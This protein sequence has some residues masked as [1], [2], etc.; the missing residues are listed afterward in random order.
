MEAAIGQIHTCMPLRPVTLKGTTSDVQG[1]SLGCGK[2]THTQ[3][4]I[5]VS[6]K[7]P[8]ILGGNLRTEVA[9][10]PR[11][12]VTT[13][14]AFKTLSL[15]RPTDF[16]GFDY[17]GAFLYHPSRIKLCK[18]NRVKTFKGLIFRKRTLRF[19]SC[20][21]V[22]AFWFM[23]FVSCNLVLRFANL[24]IKTCVLLRR[25]SAQ[26]KTSLHFVS[27]VAGLRDRLPMLA[28][29]RYPQWRSRFLR[30]I[31]TRPNG[32]AL[33]KCILNGPYIP[34]T[35][36]S[37]M[38][39]TRL[40]MLAKQLRKYEKLSKGYNKP[41]WSRF[42]T[43]VKQ[44]HK[45]DEVSYHKL[46]DILKQYQKEVNELRAKRL[47][48]NAN[49]LPLVAT[50][51]ANQDPY[52]QT[53]KSHKSYAPS[54]KP[55]IPTRS[56]TTTRYKGK[57]IAKP[58]TPPSESAF[59]EDSDPEQAQRDKDM[60]KNDNQSGQF[61]NQRIL[62][63]AGARENV[64]SLVVQ[65][66]RIQC[67][68]SK[69]FGHF[70][71]ECGKPKRVKDS[72]YHKEKM[73]LCKQAEKG[74]VP[75]AV[76]GTDSEPLEKV[77]ND[78]RYN[79]FA[80]DLQHSEQ[81]GSISN[82]CIV[83]TNDS[84]VIPDSPEMC[85]DDIQNDQNDVESD[86][87]RVALANLIVNFK[88]DVDENK[89]IQKQL[90]KANTTL[91]QE[92]K[93]C[94]TI[95]T[96]IS[97]TLGESN[98]VRDS[99]LITLQN[100][101]IE[102]E[103]YKAFN[104]R[105][106]DYDKLKRKLNE[107]LGQ[108]A[109]KDIEIKEG[110]KLKAYEIS[111]VKE[112]HDELIKQSLLTKSQYEGLVKQKTKV[113][114]DLK[115]KEEH[116]IDKMLSL[117]KQVTFLNEIVYKQN[118]SIQTIHMMVPKVP[119]YNGRPTFANPS[120]LKQDQSE[121]PCLYAFPYDQ[122]THAN[123]LIPDGGSDS[124]SRKREP[125]FR[126][127]QMKDKVVPNNSQVKLKKTQVE[128]HPRIPS[129]SNKNKSVIACN[130][131]LNSRTSNANAVCAT[132]RKCFVDFDHFACVTKMLN[133][134][135]A[136]TKKPHVVPIS[137]RKPKGHANKSIATPHKKKV[138]S[139]STTQKP[140]SY[141]RML[142]GKSSKAWKW[143]IEQQ[144]P[145]GY[146]WV[147]MTKM[148]W[149]PKARNENVQKR[150]V[151]LILFIVDSGCTK[152]TTGNLM[153]LCNFVEKVYYIE[154]LNH[155][156]FSVGQFCDADLEVAFQK[157]TCFVRDL[158]G[159]NLLIGNRGSDLYTISLQESTSS[160]PLRL[161]AKA[162][163]TQAWLWHRRL[164]YLN[165]DYISLLSKKD[166]VIGLPKLKF[167]KDQLCSSCEVSKAKRSSFKSKAIPSLKKRLNLLHIDLCGL[168][169]GEHLDKIK[170]KGDLCILVRYS[171]Q[172]K[173]YRV[174]NKRTKLIVESIY[175]RFDEIKDMS[176]TSVAN[177]TSGLVPQRQKASDYDN[178]DP[179]EGINFE[180]SF[181]PVARLEAVWIFV[182]YAAHK[183]FIIYQMDVNIKFLNGPLKEEVYVAQPEGYV[184]PDHPE[185]VYR[186]R[187]ALY[188]LK[189][190]LMSWY[191]ELSKFLTSKGF[192]KG[193][194]IH[195]SPLGIFI[196]Q[197]KYALEILHKH[198]MEKGQSIGTPMA[199]KPKL[200]ADLSGNPVDQTDYHSIIKS[201]MYLT[202][203]RSDIVQVVCYY[204]RYQ[205]RSTEKHLKEVKRIFRYLRGTINMGLW[206]PKGSSS[207]LTA[208][209]DADHARCIDTRK[210]TSGGIQ[211]LGDKLVSWMSKKQ[212]MEILIQT[213][214]MPLSLKT[215]NDSFIFV[216]ELK[217]EMHADLKYVESLENEIDELESDKAEFSNMYDMILQE[218]VSNEVMCTYLLSLSDL[219]A[220]AE[221]Q[222]LYLHR[223][224]ECDC[225]AQKL[226]KQ[227]ESISN[228][229]HAKLLQHF[230]KVE[231]HS[232]SLEIALQK[233]KGK[234]VE[235]K[236]DKPSIVRHPNAQR[237]PKPSV[238]GKPAPF[239]N[240]LERIYFSKTKSVPKTNVSKGLSK[241]V[242]A[243]TLPQTTKK[244]I[245][246]INVLKPGMYRIDKRTTQTR[247]LQSSQTV[248]N[249]NPHV[250]TFTG[251]N[252]KT[253][254][255]R[256]QYMSNQMKDKVVSNNSQVKLK[257]TRVEDHPRIP[258][259]SNKIKSVITCDDSLNSRT[260]NANA[261]CATCGK[262]LVDSDHFACVTK[263]LNDVNART[264]KPNVVPISTRKPK[265]HAT[266]SVATPNKKKVAS[267]ST[268][269]KT[270]SYY[271][272]MYEKTNA[273]VSL[274]QELDLLFGPLY[275]GLFTTGTSSINKSS[276]PTNNSNQQETQPTM[277]IQPISEPSTPTYV[278]AE[279][280]NDNQAEEEHLQDD[281]FT[282]LF[283]H[284]LEQV[285]RNP[286][287]PVQTRRQL[288]TDPEMCKFA[289]TVSTAE[290]INI[291][292]AMADSAWIEAMQEELHQFDRLQ[293]Y[294]HE[295]GID[296]EESFAPV[297]RLEAIQIFVAYVAHKSFPIYQMDMKT[298]FLN[299]PLNEEV[300]V[301]Q[302]DGFV[303]PDHLEKDC[304][305]MSSAEA[306]YVALSASCAQVMR[307]RTQ[308]QDY[309]LNYN[310]MPFYY[311]SQ[312]A[313]TILSNPVQHS[314]TKHIH[315]RYYFIKE[316][317]ENGI[318]KLYF[319]RTE[320][321]LADMFTKALLEDRFKY[322]IR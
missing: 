119:T 286:S 33:W 115:L 278:H 174:Y 268:T 275:D 216:H 196:N 199:M 58:I 213:C 229:V 270:K 246:N 114:M 215:Q 92:L 194:Q 251:V 175:I 31:D 137:T 108:L 72:A 250:S 313:I 201:L 271:R 6:S 116:D 321:Q 37:K 151:Q 98:S 143:W 3:I 280:N 24:K 227:T 101:H 59:E 309:G 207:G 106:I 318:I 142:Y 55:L 226:S 81:S 147:P 12:P 186:L 141:Y 290:L 272:M 61:G 54:S 42:V 177:D 255:S 173:G 74:E 67:F 289:L 148:Q 26:F 314:L 214:F 258:S 220:L 244:V 208:F 78:T 39:Y 256:P 305:A 230:A 282:N 322:L 276:S 295:E 94:K 150:I 88:L 17:I 122:S 171:T 127:N 189:Q 104:D 302:P 212:D 128:D 60:Y 247:A 239:S 20:V 320:Y 27:R 48:R 261:V 158:Q 113:I 254:V 83:E 316:Q 144:C 242:T 45:L 117:E 76:T 156:L 296:F 43:I 64:G 56:H 192:T 219:D 232:I 21:L 306:E 85:D 265:G 284:P 121:I 8:R 87:E 234:S 307:M 259:I 209:L 269:Q 44:Q 79:V 300:Y 291:M 157:S 19:G 110:L 195:Q 279:K 257:K 154:G 46:F 134:V 161:M 146:T 210:S 132:C 225:L 136:R 100:K 204:A 308:L 168:I 264:K 205:S 310:N 120:Y 170:E 107:T 10:I 273:H 73:L 103:K 297:A 241:P 188:G 91:T 80:N 180:E 41:E 203:S 317:V 202:A 18:R 221:L 96:E 298:A 68:N 319:V 65:Q 304:T 172:S 312:S 262:C 292:E 206:Y 140:K 285:R 252:H 13:T 181:A 16:Y 50:T 218:S 84:N 198:G 49:P 139:K 71:K 217:Q 266:K 99:C 200:D 238:L 233:C 145:L 126:S 187:K 311:D 165:F 162:S 25:D 111:V 224:K 164:S 93:V 231:K 153:L 4:S 38:K 97:K 178:S 95:L 124:Y 57:E 235:T 86:D 1:V 133:D 169:D 260:S 89:K 245:S 82:T 105:T 267:K 193:L 14:T 125:Q 281:E 77:Q 253:N 32:D 228:E 152:Y 163:P 75:T 243:Q 190:A 90:K 176:E 299:G 179:E 166:V 191:D 130:D 197:A 184:D 185:K 62:N 236:F 70:A 47:A 53:S 274:Q 40:L 301:A 135:N 223:V 183:S 7:W 155:N 11:T 2:R 287:K 237:I 211:F 118:Q 277:N 149:V 249:T 182:A 109:Q 129:I 36:E 288:A 294:A 66:S 112:K 240:S 29:G 303:D 123:R 23:R 315:T 63:V 52:Y 69:E 22:P 160:T 131:S 138:A 34:T 51:Q 293:G 167:V 222:C 15:E 248:R 102:F 283:Y 28:T 30:Y 159:N 9:Q 5:L 35:V 263:M